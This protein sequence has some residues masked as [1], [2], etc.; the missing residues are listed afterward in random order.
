MFPLIK[1]GVK[2][3]KEGHRKAKA[4]SS[5]SPQAACTSRAAILTEK[6]NSIKR[7][8][9]KDAFFDKHSGLFNNVS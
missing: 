6:R 8:G 1:Q 9:L 4:L 7:L 5:P 2:Q 3:D